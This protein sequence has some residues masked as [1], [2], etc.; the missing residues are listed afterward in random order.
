MINYISAW[1]EQVIIC[2]IV[3]TVL[4]MILPKGNSKKYIKTIMGV[5][6]L[7]VII[8]PAIKIITGGDMKIKY[9]EYEK[10]FNTQ[11][12]VSEI[13]VPKV[14]DTYKTELEKQIKLD[15]EKIGYDVN[16]VTT[17][18]DINEGIIKQVEINANKKTEE[19]DTNNIYINK[20]EIGENLQKNKLGT[21]EIEQIKQKIN[22]D[23]GVDMKNIT[24]NSM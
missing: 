14:E 3:I 20:I 8:S 10:Y 4:E 6:I 23:Y 1:A 13:D 9:S 19:K 17:I 22:E 7:Y 15:I 11:E 2:V 18:F 12:T 21:E 5:Y 24:V 16:K